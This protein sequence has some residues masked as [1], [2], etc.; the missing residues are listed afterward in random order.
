MKTADIKDLWQAEGRGSIPP[1]VTD[2][3]QRAKTFYGKIGRRNWIEYAAAAL[4]VVGFSAW[5][6]TEE[7]PLVRLGLAMIAAGSLFVGWQ[8]RRRASL[9]QS[10]IAPTLVEAIAYYRAQLAR[11]RDALRSV[12]SWYLLP[13]LPGMLLVLVGR[14]FLSGGDSEEGAPLA[15]LP[16]LLLVALVFGLVWWANRKAADKMQEQIDE[17]DR[18]KEE[19]E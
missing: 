19:L 7:R 2:V 3:H 12:W 15:L 14:A 9:E 4:V 6:L 13:L 1:R 8:M 16:V 5:A 11:Q 10:P 17:L 18:M